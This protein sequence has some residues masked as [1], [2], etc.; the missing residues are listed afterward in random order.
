MSFNLVEG[1]VFCINKPATWS[2]FDVVNRLKF[3]I[4]KTENRKWI[5]VGHAGTL[6]PL[7]TGL[8]V[9]CT[10]KETKNIDLIQG[11]PKTYTGKLK[12][13]MVTPSF[14]L[15]TEPIEINPVPY[16]T[17]DFLDKIALKYIGEIDQIPPIYSALKV[18]GKRAY[19]YAR[20]GEVL[21]MKSRKITIYNLKLEKVEPDILYFEVNCSKGTYIRSLV[22]DIGNDLEC[23][24][25]MIELCRTKI[26]DYSLESA[27]EL[28]DL[29]TE[30]IPL[31][32]A[33]SL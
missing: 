32:E 19:D 26:G 18:N 4:G 30:I 1:E 31:N 7:A 16:F 24:A 8:L 28:N 13:G 22:S 27:W 2:S 6:D 20:E 25:T 15:E 5:K 3:K 23:G 29:L 21:E 10:G 14:D 9:V 17:A 33:N 12:L 11:L